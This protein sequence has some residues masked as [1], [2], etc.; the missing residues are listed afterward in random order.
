MSETQIGQRMKNGILT[1]T[2]LLVIGFTGASAL[3]W[4]RAQAVQAAV[5]S[6][7]TELR[8]HGNL[9]QCQQV[10][11]EA[12]RHIRLLIDGHK[13]PLVLGGLAVL[14]SLATLANELRR[15]RK[16]WVLTT[17]AG[18]HTISMTAPHER[19]RR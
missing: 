9:E 10:E 4:A 7:I 1:A 18:R 5:V 8:D 19:E 13:A 11:R 16:A 2:L 3:N 14:S 6:S 12:G 15:K 17:M